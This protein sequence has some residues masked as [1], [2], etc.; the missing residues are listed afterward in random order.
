MADSL[1]PGLYCSGGEVVQILGGVGSAGVRQ[2]ALFLAQ[3]LANVIGARPVLLQAPAVV[4]TAESKRVLMREPVMRETFDHFDLLDMALVGFGSMDPSQLLASSG[5]V[6]S[7]AERDELSATVP[8]AVHQVHQCD[9][10]HHAVGWD[11][12][13]LHGICR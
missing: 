10:D 3:R 13:H 4:A 6:F 8:D 2:E 9:V 12:G 7:P 1:H 11:I 5:N